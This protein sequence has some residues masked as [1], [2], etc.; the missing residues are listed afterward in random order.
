[1]TSAIP[2]ILPHFADD[3]KVELARICSAYGALEQDGVAVTRRPMRSNHT[4]SRQSIVGGG[5]GI[6]RPGEITLS[7]LGVLFLEEIAEF[8]TSKIEALRQPIEAGEIVVSGAGATL[9]FPCRFTLVAAMNPCPCGYFGSDLCRCKDIDVKKYQKKLSGPILDRID[10][11]VEMERL[12]TDERFAATEVELSHRLRH[13]IEKAREIQRGRF[14]GKSIPYNAAI[15][16]GA[17]LDFCDLSAEAMTCYREV[18]D[19]NT[20]TTRSMDRLAKVAR[21]IA[22]L[23]GCTPVLPQHVGTASTF[24]VGGILRNQF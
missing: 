9:Q 10:L 7:H 19:K 8:P 23:E 14:C 1:L 12:T 15:P 18:I 5:S 6:P 22:G 20:L 2:G 21:T 11:Q 17:V 16:G 3:E 4:A 24:V 13:K